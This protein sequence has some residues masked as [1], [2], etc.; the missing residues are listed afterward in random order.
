MENKNKIL[1]LIG[2]AAR[3]RLISTGVDIVVGSVQKRKAKF[4]F[5]ANDAS[6]ETIKRVLDKCNYYNV[7]TTSLFNTEE[8]N[9]AVGKNN[10]KTLSINDK[11]FYESIKALI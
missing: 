5:I 7:E 2:L 10:I 4:V 9:S 3:A 1:N 11:G 6:K 8:L